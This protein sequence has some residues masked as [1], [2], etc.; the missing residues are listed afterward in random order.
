[1]PEKTKKQDLLPVIYEPL[2]LYLCLRK[3]QVSPSPDVPGYHGNILRVEVRYQAGCRDDP[4]MLLKKNYVEVALL[5]VN[6][7]LDH[8]M[9]PSE[10]SAST[11]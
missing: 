8:P 10:V 4:I 5:M 11:L 9:V 1:M 6:D 2:F 3:Q 7:E